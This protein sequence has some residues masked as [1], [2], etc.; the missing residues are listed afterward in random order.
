MKRNWYKNR[1]CYYFDDIE[2]FN[3]DN[4]VTDEKLY[5][6]ILFYSISYK[7]LIAKPLHVRFDK[8]NGLEFVMALD[9]QYYL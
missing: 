1:T 4:I 5:E 2:E 9:I 8:I 7:N 6:N 3:L